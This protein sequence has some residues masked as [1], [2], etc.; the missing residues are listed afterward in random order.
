[1]RLSE[2][3]FYQKITDIYA[4]SIKSPMTI[5]FFKKI[6]NKMRSMCFGNGRTPDINRI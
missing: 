4:N 2:R 6:Q 1:M 5:K 3:R